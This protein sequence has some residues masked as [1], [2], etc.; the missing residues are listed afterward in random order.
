MCGICDYYKTLL[1]QQNYGSFIGGAETKESLPRSAETPTGFQGLPDEPEDVPVARE[2][3]RASPL[4]PHDPAA[5]VA[6]RAPARA[7][8]VSGGGALQVENETS[9]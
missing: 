6:R 4:H 5:P 8:Q 7:F 1:L 3:S 2:R 9:G